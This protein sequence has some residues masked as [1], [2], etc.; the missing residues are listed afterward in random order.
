M[1]LFG[2]A[3][4][5]LCLFCLYHVH[6]CVRVLVKMREWFKSM[7]SVYVMCVYVSV[8]MHAFGCVSVRLGAFYGCIHVRVCACVG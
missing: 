8:C 5:C 2:C 1:H 4:V 6:V 7:N 3:S